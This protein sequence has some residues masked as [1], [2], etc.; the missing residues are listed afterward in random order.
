[1]KQNVSRKFLRKKSNFVILLDISY[2]FNSVNWMTFNVWLL[3]CFLGVCFCGV[4]FHRRNVSCYSVVWQLSNL[5]HF[6]G[7]YFL[8]IQF[9]K[10]FSGSCSQ[11]AFEFIFIGSNCSRSCIYCFEEENSIV[12][13]IMFLFTYSFFFVIQYATVVLTLM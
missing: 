8:G 7:K 6:V 4:I 13:R 1:M 11:I 12:C 2:Q 10:C 5:L 9:T 3:C